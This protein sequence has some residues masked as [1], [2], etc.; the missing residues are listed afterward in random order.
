MK[1]KNCNQLIE[2]IHIK[3]WC[4]ICVAKLIAREETARAEGSTAA[5]QR[6]NE[7]MISTDGVVSGQPLIELVERAFKTGWGARGLPDYGKGT[8]DVLEIQK[9]LHS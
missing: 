4:P 5:F 8:E 1:C 2:I 7:G 6:S 9:T 3:E